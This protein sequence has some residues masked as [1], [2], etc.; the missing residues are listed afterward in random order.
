MIRAPRL[1]GIVS[2]HLKVVHRQELSAPIG[3]VST[4]LQDVVG[5]IK[6]DK[7]T[8]PLSLT[9]I[10]WLHRITA[11]I[12]SISHAQPSLFHTS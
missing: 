4:A 8:K 11:I 2:G 9:D 6:G 7:L 1:C 12:I 5:E 10:D 3:G